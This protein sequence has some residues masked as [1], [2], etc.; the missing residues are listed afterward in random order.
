MR[1]LF[2]GIINSR[3]ATY[4]GPEEIH[5]AAMN[6]QDTTGQLIYQYIVDNDIQ[7]SMIAYIKLFLRFPFEVIGIYG[8]H[9]VNAFFILYPETYIEDINKS[10]VGYCILSLFIIFLLLLCV[11]YLLKSCTF[12]RNK[13]FLLIV[14]AMPSIFILAGAVE[15]R[16]LVLPYMMIYG[17]LV[18]F[19]EWKGI[20]D[21][22]RKGWI[23]Y[24]I[25]FIVFVT[26]A[27]A[28]ET[29]ILANLNQTGS[30]IDKMY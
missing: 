30:M 10:R 16:F 24:L 22:V 2:W 9:L 8:K 13:F 7:Q 1:Q 28:V 21:A 25:L 5:S 29:D 19:G 12:N 27:L 17:F 18:H 4:L 26:I 11:A 14:M 6:Y 15:E 3:Y 20:V 23:K